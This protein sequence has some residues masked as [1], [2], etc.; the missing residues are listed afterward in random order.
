M[1]CFPIYVYARFMLYCLH[2][3]EISSK[4][5]IYFQLE[6]TLDLTME[7]H[8]NKQNK[9]NKHHDYY[10]NHGNHGNHDPNYHHRQGHHGTG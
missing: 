9:Q 5:Y 1:K 8:M 3:K 7:G 2:L 6:Y 4:C 10:G